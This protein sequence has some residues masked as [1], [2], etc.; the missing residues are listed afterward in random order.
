MDGRGSQR[1][2]KPVEAVVAM[3]DLLSNR[4]YARR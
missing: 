4:P 3:T 2:R 1:S